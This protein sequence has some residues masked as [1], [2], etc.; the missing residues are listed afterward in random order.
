M[1]TQGVHPDST[2][3]SMESIF[4]PG[5]WM[6]TAGVGILSWQCLGEAGMVIGATKQTEHP[7]VGSKLW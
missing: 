2:G 4:V 6:L 5:I 3:V 7:T 1:R